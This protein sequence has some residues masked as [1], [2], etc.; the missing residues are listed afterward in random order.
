MTKAVNNSSGGTDPEKATARPSWWHTKKWRWILAG[1]GIAIV[2]LVVILGAALG[3]LNSRSHAELRSVETDEQEACAYGGGDCSPASTTSSDSSTSPSSTTGPSLPIITQAAN[4]VPRDFAVGIGSDPKSLFVWS[5]QGGEQLSWKKTDDSNWVTYQSTQFLVAPVIV[6]TSNDTQMAFAIKAPTGALV[7]TEYSDGA[8]KEDDWQE[9]GSA[10]AWQPSAI[11]VLDGSVDVFNI[12][13]NGDVLHK[14]YSDDSKW[15]EW[16][17]V[18]TGF[19]G[20][21]SVT[22][23]SPGRLDVLASTGSEI[24]HKFLGS[25]GW[26]DE[27]TSLGMPD[28]ASPFKGDLQGWPLAVSWAE[29]LMDVVVAS[30]GFGTRHK[31]YQD[32]EWGAEWQGLLASHEGYEFANTQC[33]TKGGVES[34]FAHLLSRGTDDCIHYTYFNGSDWASWTY[35]WCNRDYSRTD[36]LTRNLSLSATDDGNGVLDIVARNTTGDLIHYGLQLPID[37]QFSYQDI[38][39]DNLGKG[40]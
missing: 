24:K 4:N 22:S 15:S 38:T 25:D 30:E 40:A 20:E 6:P 21:V 5:L 9:L 17:T 23:S 39:W 2:I 32:G 11:S 10:F 8:W 28:S 3:T 33:L 12:D 27:W 19:T 37:S 31:K 16:E 26:S 1:A 35:M 29:G 18:G 34:P 13:I 36:Y 14:S 7:Y